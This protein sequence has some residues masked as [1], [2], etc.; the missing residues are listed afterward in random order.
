MDDWKVPGFQYELCTACQACVK[1]CP[2]HA[3]AMVSAQP[4]LRP[5]VICTYCG[6]CEDSCPTGAVFLTYEIVLGDEDAG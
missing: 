2:E 3:L 5:E 1:V 6:L 4:A